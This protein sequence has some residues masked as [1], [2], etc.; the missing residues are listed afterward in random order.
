M[1]NK[2]AVMIGC[3][4]I[5]CSAPAVSWW[6]EWDSCKAQAGYA[7]TDCNACQCADQG[8]GRNPC[9]SLSEYC[10]VYGNIGSR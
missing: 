1:K 6:S 7:D 3:L 4:T 10:H 5:A 9:M 8:Y 2:L